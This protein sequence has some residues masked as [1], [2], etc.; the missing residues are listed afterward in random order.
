M[1]ESNDATKNQTS[2]EEIPVTRTPDS[3]VT[4]QAATERQLH[5]TEAKIE[6]QIDK[7]MSAFERSMLRLTWAA[8]VISILSFLVFGGQLY[9]MWSGGN[10]AEDATRLDQRAWVV[11]AGIG[12][13]PEINKPWPLTLA[14]TNTGKTPAVNTWIACKSEVKAD[15]ESIDWIPTDNLHRGPA[16]VAPNAPAQCVLHPITGPTVTQTDLDVLKSW[17]AYAFGTVV[18]QDIFDRWHWLTFC[19]VMQPEKAGWG[20][21]QRGNETGDGA[22]PPAPFDELEPRPKD[23]N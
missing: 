6:Q 14:L 3:P 2:S 16:L 7:R 23:P 4:E 9:E 20:P 10:S 12:P 15:E 18:Y 13:F 11:T 22:R 5:D 8:T 17:H 21:C 19:Q 1:N